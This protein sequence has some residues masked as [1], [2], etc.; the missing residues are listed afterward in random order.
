MTKRKD[1]TDIAK[2]EPHDPYAIHDI[3]QLL[4]LF[5]GGE[6]LAEFNRDHRDLLQQ[7]ADHNADFGTKS[8]KGSFKLEVSYELGAAGD[9]GMKV[10]AD[11]K[12]PKKPASLAAAF[13]G[14]GGQM[15]LYSPMMKRMQPGVRD[16]TG[17][18]QETGEIRD[19]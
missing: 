12:G 10:T 1:T 19:V 7:L 5:E 8:A 3:L 9:L 17:Y 11:F 6:F 4:T 2:V 16:V 13:V 18:D 14:E 15:T